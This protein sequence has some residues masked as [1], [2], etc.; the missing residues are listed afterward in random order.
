MKKK[1][2]GIGG[3]FFRSQNKDQAQEWYRKHLGI[4]SE[5]YGCHSYLWR[6]DE[7]PDKRGY[8]VWSPFARDTEYFGSQ[9]QEYMVNY[10]VED[11]VG[12]LE[13]LKSDGVEIVGELKE[14]ANGKF[15]WILDGEG[16]R[17]ELW[18]PV[19]S[20]QDPYLG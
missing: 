19:P 9:D 3:V 4:D 20:D 5:P 12:L 6:D 16:H 15:A 8:T 2:T 1:V 17:V 14:E 11:L 18:E 7:D 13:E 10:R